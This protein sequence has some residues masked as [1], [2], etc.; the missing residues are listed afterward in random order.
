MNRLYLRWIR[1][2]PL[3]ADHMPQIS[4]TLPCELALRAL[5]QPFVFCQQMKHLPDMLHMLLEGLAINK[6]VIKEDEHTYAEERFQS[7]IHCTLEC[8]RS[9]CQTKGHYS[10]FKVSPMSLECQFMFLSGS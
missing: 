10:P 1:G 6:Y 8:V 9:P 3:Y 2:H 7:H 5:Q 4:D